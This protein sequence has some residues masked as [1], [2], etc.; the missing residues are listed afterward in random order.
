MSYELN[1]HRRG[2][3]AMVAAI[4]WHGVAAEV[5]HG[6]PGRFGLCGRLIICIQVLHCKHAE[7]VLAVSL[8]LSCTE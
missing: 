5:A 7:E 6:G 1:M 3:G 8:I 4:T 2:G